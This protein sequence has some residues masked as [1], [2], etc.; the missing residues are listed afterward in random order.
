LLWC[1]WLK[2]GEL[3]FTH[4]NQQVGCSMLA[5]ACM[6]NGTENDDDDDDDDETDIIGLPH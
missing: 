2:S 5:W 3:H 4:N 1:L 6:Q